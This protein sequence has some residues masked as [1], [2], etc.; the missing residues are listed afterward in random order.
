MVIIIKDNDEYDQRTGAD[1]GS[2]VKI[3]SA[4]QR[5]VTAT[6]LPM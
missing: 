6:P 2:S 5:A 1:L 3:V 4:F